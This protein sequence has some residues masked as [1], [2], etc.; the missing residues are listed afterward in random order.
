MATEIQKGHLVKVFLFNNY[1][2]KSEIYEFE[3]DL[4]FDNDEFTEYEDLVDD[5]ELTTTLDVLDSLIY[6]KAFGLFVN[7][8]GSIEE[9]GQKSYSLELQVV[10]SNGDIICESEGFVNYNVLEG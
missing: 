10:D 1:P 6:N 4:I 3:S 2:F 5:P 7:N 8:Y 9:W